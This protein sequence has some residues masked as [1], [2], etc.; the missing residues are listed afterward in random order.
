MKDLLNDLDPVQKEAV[1]ATDG[2]VLIMAGAGSGKTRVLTYKIA[3][4]ISKGVKPENILA[5]TFTNKAANEMKERVYNLLHRHP[6]VATTTMGSGDSIASLQ[7]DKKSADS[8]YVGTFHAFCAKLLRFDGKYIGIPSGYLIYDDDDSLSL[9]KKIMK[10]L[11]ISIKNFKPSSILNA[12]SGAK[13]ELMGPADYAQFARGYFS[14]TVSKVYNIY[15]KTLLEIN[16]CDFDDLLMQ[17]VKLFETNPQILEKWAGRFEYVLVDEYQDVNTAQ[18]QLTK[19]LASM[20]GNLTV[21]GDAA[22]A[23]YSFRGADFRNI[24]NFKM[25]F[26][27]AKVFNLEQ[28]YRSTGNILSAANKIISH[29][30][31]HP[32][33]KLWTK[34]DIGEKIS[35]YGAM[36]E[37]DE[38]NFIVDRIMGSRKPLS[39]FAVLYRTNAQ[40]RT[41]EE[42]F[43]HS[44]IP[45]KL[46]GG[47]SFYA[48]KEVKDVMAYL[49][50]IANPRDMVS[51]NRTLKLG[52]RRFEKFQEMVEKLNLRE[53][54]IARSGA[55]KQS[56][57][58]IA[59]SSQDS[60]R[61]DDKKLPKPI[62]LIDMVL[63][64]TDYLR[65][66]DDGTEEGL[67][68]VENVKELKSVAADF[69][70][71][72]QFLENV[73]LMEGKV[74]PEKSYE[75]PITKDFVTLMTIHAA[76]GLEF[77][78]VFIVG[79]EEGL[80]PHSRSMLETGQ[81]EEERRLAYVGL[82]RARKKLYLS[83]AAH[84]LYF[85]TTSANLVSRFI[86]DI[87]EELVSAI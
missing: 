54:V 3:Y 46:Y 38:A 30:A 81:L 19:L 5:S 21:V 83:Y 34:N 39:A 75:L 37:V 24:L 8:P 29:N 25:D 68:R 6:G 28:N 82:T 15:Q 76:K 64:T 40:S 55:T 70:N 65:V 69:E 36:N 48:R 80:F 11:D 77:D 71:L 4:L 10:D 35:I 12:I 33:L 79:M 13:G 31:S 1:L 17:T 51:K 52:K 44:N 20:H 57:K 27:N 50:L 73:T 41:V 63:E 59:A 42:A 87:P 84:R 47:V 45:Y 23:I 66:I 56:E 7:N 14:E 32:V 2:P 49:R 43:L 58:K 74:A 22:Q 78:D 16:A 26:P 85:G 18:Y 72:S 61:N 9:I 86:V 62:E 67:S 60:T 53:H